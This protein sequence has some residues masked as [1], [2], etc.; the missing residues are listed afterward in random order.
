M[1]VVTAAVYRNDAA[2]CSSLDAL[3][4]L[5]VLEFTA[6]EI[7]L[8]A[9]AVRDQRALSIGRSFR[10]N[11]ARSCFRFQNDV[12]CKATLNTSAVAVRQF[13]SLPAM[14]PAL[15]MLPCAE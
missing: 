12:P 3:D 9:I 11:A 2:D 10:C 8:I 15:K 6:G 14:P 1:S 13:A 5:R 7:K 4:A